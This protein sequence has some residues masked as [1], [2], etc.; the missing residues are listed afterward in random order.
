V[1]D[2]RPISLLTSE[3]TLDEAIDPVFSDI[4]ILDYDDV[5]SR[6]AG[7][8]ADDWQVYNKSPYLETIK[9]E[10][11]TI[12]TQSLDGWWQL[13]QHR[14]LVIATGCRTFKNQTATN[15]YYRRVLDQNLLPDVYNA[16]TYF[17]RSD[18]AKRFYGIV[19]NIFG[20]WQKINSSLT[21]ASDLPWGDTDTVYAIAASVIG[22]N[23]CTIP[24]TAIQITHMKQHINNLSSSDWTQELTWELIGNEFRIN[25]ISQLTPVHYHVKHLAHLLEP[26]YDEYLSTI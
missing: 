5:S 14:D 23:Q 11:D 18:T 8:Y 2:T 3:K 16:V 6:T 1:G 22:Y 15:R 17:K 10:A 26:L 20:N 7:Q 24:N 21:T 13:L 19:R 4:D 9:L 12:V 25:T